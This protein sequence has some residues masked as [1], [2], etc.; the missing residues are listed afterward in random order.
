MY[1]HI[2][3]AISTGISEATTPTISEISGIFSA[4]QCFFAFPS[5]YFAVSLV[6]FAVTS[7]INYLCSGKPLGFR[8]ID[9]S[10]SPGPTPNR[11]ALQ[12]LN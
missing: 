8:D 3:I 4:N 9:K 12:L 10:D 6:Y 1:R 2:S 7:P 11:L 5:I